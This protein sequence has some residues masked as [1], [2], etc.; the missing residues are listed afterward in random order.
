MFKTRSIRRRFI[1]LP[2]LALLSLAGCENTIAGVEDGR[3]PWPALEGE[4]G[5]ALGEFQGSWRVTSVNG[6][7]LSVTVAYADAQNHV[8][9][10]SGRMDVCGADAYVTKNYT[11]TV[12]GDSSPFQE[13]G[14]ARLEN[15]GGTT[16]F[17]RTDRDGISTTLSV[18]G[19]TLTSTAPSGDVER[20]QR[21]SSDASC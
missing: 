13:T 11:M 15:D 10:N 2:V 4:G 19:S 6:E 17:I 9:L 8:V 7:T 3:F 5:G 12:S 16:R 1:A 21:T 14:T 18:S 20:W